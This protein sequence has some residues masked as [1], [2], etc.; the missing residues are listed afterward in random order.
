MEKVLYESRFW[1]MT[2]YPDKTLMRYT[3]YSSTNEMTEAEYKEEMRKNAEISSSVEVKSGLIDLRNFLYSISADVQSWT[4]REIFP[5]LSETGYKKLAFLVSKDLFAQ[6]SVEQ[7]L[8]EEVAAANFQ[9][10]YFES[11]EEAQEWLQN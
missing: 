7:M 8:D 9:T 6:V 1:R 10:R 3:W 2:Y 5:K 11:E 4:D